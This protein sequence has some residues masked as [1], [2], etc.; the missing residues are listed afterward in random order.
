M[1]GNVDLLT[2]GIPDPVSWVNLLNSLSAVLW[3][4]IYIQSEADRGGGG[5][6]GGEGGGAPLTS[7]SYNFIIY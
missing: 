6:G 7:A 1:K 5:G 4:C 2:A 3:P